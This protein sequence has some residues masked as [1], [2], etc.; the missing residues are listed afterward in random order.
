MTYVVMK[1]KINKKICAEVINQLLE[2]WP[3][4]QEALG[5]ILSISKTGHGGAFL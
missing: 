4:M 1:F 2:Y 5:S 3:S